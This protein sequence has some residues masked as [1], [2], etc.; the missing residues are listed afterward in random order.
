MPIDATCRV[1]Y[2]T[3]HRILVQSILMSVFQPKP[4]PFDI[5]SDLRAQLRLEGWRKV[6]ESDLNDKSGQPSVRGG[7]AE[8]NFKPC[9]A[10]IDYPLCRKQ[11][12]KAATNNSP[13]AECS[14]FQDSTNSSHGIHMWFST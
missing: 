1:T 6:T 5:C 7:F 4:M 11:L 14:Y 9:P 10:S 2:W 12:R 8:T 3:V 13:R